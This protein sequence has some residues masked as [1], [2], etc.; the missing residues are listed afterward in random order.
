VTRRWVV[1]VVVVV[2]VRGITVGHVYVH[3][4]NKNCHRPLFHE[5]KQQQQQHNLLMLLVHFVV[6][7]LVRGIIGVA[8]RNINQS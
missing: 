3:K 5:L 4:L 2:L 6:V 7:V 8:S 1:V